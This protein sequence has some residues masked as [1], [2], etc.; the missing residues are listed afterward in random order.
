MT[1]SFVVAL[2]A[3]SPELTRRCLASM[4]DELREQTFV[5]DN[6]TTG[7]IRDEHSTTVMFARAHYANAGV[8]RSWNEGVQLADAMRVDYIILL[9]QS[10][11]FGPQGGRDFIA[12]LEER[13]PEWIMHAQHGWKTIALSLRWFD[14]VGLFDKIFTPAYYEESDMLRRAHLAGLP[15]PLYNDGRYDQVTIDAFSAGDAR[16][17]KDGL[18]TIDY[19]AQLA[20]Y[21]A[22]WGGP[23]CAETYSTPYDDET[24]DWTFVGEHA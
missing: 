11:T 3:I 20:K 8:P 7:E 9:S 1:P 22:K 4:H 5:L 24:C 13:K 6:T 21:V 14:V 19:G 23:P 10:I 16:A 15:C 12:A 2:P 17:L 18:V